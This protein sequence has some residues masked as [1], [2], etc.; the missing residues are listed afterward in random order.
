VPFFKA[1]VEAAVCWSLERIIGTEETLLHQGEWQVRAGDS[2]R[3]LPRLSRRRA[4]ITFSE[5]PGR[6]SNY[7]GRPGQSQQAKIFG[8]IFRTAAAGRIKFQVA[9]IPWRE[10]KGSSL[11]KHWFGEVGFERSVILASLRYLS[12]LFQKQESRNEAGLPVF[13]F[14]LFPPGQ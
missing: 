14:R 8:V 1:K 10:K 11:A 5:G 9:G 4:A 6:H 2:L 7:A 13:V 3:A 12:P